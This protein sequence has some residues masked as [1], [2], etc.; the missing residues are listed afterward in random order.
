MMD[1]NAVS[2]L[3]ILNNNFPSHDW[4]VN[5]EEDGRVSVSGKEKVRNC[6]HEEAL[7]RVYK[8]EEKLRIEK[9]LHPIF[10]RALDKKTV[11]GIKAGMITDSTIEDEDFDKPKEA[12]SLSAKDIDKAYEDVIKNY[13]NDYQGHFGIPNTEMYLKYVFDKQERQN[14]VPF[15]IPNTEMYLKYVF[16]KQERQNKVPFFVKVRDKLVDAIA[17]LYKKSKYIFESH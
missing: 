13:Y 10:E 14:K 9:K 16:D 8:K 15:G 7:N 11:D 6:A 2:V 1:F 5:I 17:Q 3:D 4:D 12:F